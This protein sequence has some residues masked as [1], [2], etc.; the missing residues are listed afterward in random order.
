MTTTEHATIFSD[1]VNEIT[2]HY[3]RGRILIAI[4]GVDGD[5]TG[6]FA[7]S[8]ASAMRAKSRLVVR[9]SSAPKAGGP[10]SDFSFPRCDSYRVDDDHSPLTDIVSRFREGDLGISDSAAVIP[11]VVMLIVDGRFLLR[12]EL[13]TVWHFKVW[14]E[15]DLNLS[16]ESLESQIRYTRDGAP[17]GAADAIFKVT[18]DESPTRVWADS[19]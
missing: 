11:A 19:C 6:H 16:G 5:V 10:Q 3:Y 4:D 12:P 8:L 18:E 15:G 1:L 13:R 2:Q 14:L 17:R 9:A 7:N